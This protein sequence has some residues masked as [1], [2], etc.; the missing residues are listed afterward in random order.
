MMKKPQ[1]ARCA[2]VAIAASAALP[3]T[4]VL[5]QDAAT[6]EPTIIFPPVSTDPIA[7]PE[8]VAP[9][10][11]V[12][13]TQSGPVRQDPVIVLPENLSSV[14]PEP[15]AEARTTKAKSAIA[16]R[17]RVNR[18]EAAPVRQQSAT[19]VAPVTPSM[20]EP[21]S[22]QEAAAS[23]AN[24]SSASATQG[25]K[26]GATEIARA[27]NNNGLIAAIAGL[28]A[29]LAGGGLIAAIRRRRSATTL[30]D[31][32]EEQ[33][34]PLPRSENS[35]PISQPAPAVPLAGYSTLSFSSGVPESHFA[36]KAK[37]STSDPIPLPEKAPDSFEERDALLR[38]L[39][40]AKPDRANPFRSRGA[41]VR[42]ARLIIQSLNRRF[43]NAKPR[44]DLSEYSNRWPA[45]RG[46]NPAMG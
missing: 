7:P 43:E 30:D 38:R 16:S 25:G 26:E 13:T 4:P 6:A 35:A 29:V 46:W 9:P 41:R 2:A 42:R 11:P 24:L 40:E 18:A 5:A 14:T 39:V 33:T 36:V 20:K 22:L 19:P 17:A 3:L 8:S 27:D 44:I 1:I 37:S 10:A 23:E 32:E 12:V 15:A 34:Y 21:A 45:L 28:L 31:G